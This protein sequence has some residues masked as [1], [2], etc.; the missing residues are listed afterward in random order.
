MTDAPPPDAAARPDDDAGGLLGLLLWAPFAILLY[1][2]SIGPVVAL[3]EHFDTGRAA[4][5]AVYFPVIW[6]AHENDTFRDIMIRYSE[7]WGWH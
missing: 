6:L 7:L 2:L 5:R 4:V 3:V 1:V